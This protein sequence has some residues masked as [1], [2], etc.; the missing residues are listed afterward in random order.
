[1]SILGDGWGGRPPA[2]GGGSGTAGDTV[3][4]ETSFGLSSSAGVATEY[5]R[6]DHTHGTPAIPYGTVTAQTS[7]GASS[8]DGVSLDVAR[9]DH[10]H[11]T[12]A[13]SYGA[14]TAQTSYGASSSNGVSTSV[15]RADHT[16]GTPALPAIEDLSSTDIATGN[17]STLKHGLLKKLDNNAAHFMDGQGD[18][19]TPDHGSIGGLSDDDHT[20]YSLVSGSRA[21]TGRVTT[22]ATTITQ[23]AAASGTPTAGWLFTGAAHTGLS[24]AEATDIHADLARTVTFGNGGG[25]L[26]T[27]RAVRIGQVTYAAAAAMTITNASAIDV[28]G[29]PVAGSNVTLTNTWVGRFAAD[30]DSKMAIGRAVIGF[31]NGTDTATFAHFDRNNS[32]DFA[33]SQTAAGTTRIGCASGQAVRIEAI[34]TGL[35]VADNTDTNF[36]RDIVPS[37]DG[38]ANIGTHALRWGNIVMSGLVRFDNSASF[39]TTVGAAG[40][41][42][43]LPATPTKYLLIKDNSDT[44]F[45][46]PCYAAS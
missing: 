7:F 16:H 26:A 17:A 28:D 1:M 39:Q 42:S 2:G 14:V 43:A 5:S 32:T 13:I 4:A 20:Q 37:S 18:W 30:T 31:A 36:L 25:T 35:I 45:V 23:T 24:I 6:A 15:A 10:T 44:S 22:P 41:G 3:E 46:I 40:G 21:F 29:P 11:G 38:G 33:L 19:S 27:Q 12:P 8:S 34:G 9:A